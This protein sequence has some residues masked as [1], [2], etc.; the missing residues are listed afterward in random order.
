MMRGHASCHVASTGTE[1]SDRIIAACDDAQ[2]ILSR[3]QPPHQM[4]SALSESSR[5]TPKR[6]TL[7]LTDILLGIRQIYTTQ[8]E[9][10]DKI[11]F[12][13]R[14][15]AQEAEQHFP[16]GDSLCAFHPHASTLKR[17]GLAPQ[18]VALTLLNNRPQST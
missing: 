10:S 8:F 9:R 14:P 11:L 18:L 13:G 1:T 6:I 15:S 4:C 2:R 7:S 5:E 3:S 17:K 16:R 12:I